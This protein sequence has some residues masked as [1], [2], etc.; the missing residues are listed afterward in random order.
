MIGAIL[1]TF[2]WAMSPLVQGQEPDSINKQ[3]DLTRRFNGR[4]PPENR[5]RPGIIETIWGLLLSPVGCSLAQSL[6]LPEDDAQ[7]DFTAWSPY[8]GLVGVIN[9]ADQIERLASFFHHPGGPRIQGI[10]MGSGKDC[11]AGLLNADR[12]FIQALKSRAPGMEVLFVLDNCIIDVKTDPEARRQYLESV[13][14]TLGPLVDYFQVGNEPD[15]FPEE[16]G[17]TNWISERQYAQAL[18]EVYA[19]AQSQYPGVS[20]KLVPAAFLG[21][22]DGARYLGNLISLAGPLL[23]EMGIIHI[24]FYCGTKQ[25]VYD[26]KFQIERLWPRVRVWVTET[27]TLHRSRHVGYVNARYPIFKRDLHAERIYWW[28]MF[29]VAGGGQFGGFVMAL[30]DRVGGSVIET[31]PLYN[32]LLLP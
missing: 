24:H 28:H 13:F 18:S 10:R 31:S 4:I 8:V 14:R 9:P 21:N 6:T 29:N 27:G 12:K 3:V 16:A 23:T 1:F 7:L 26:Y 20:D 32:A 17:C 19:F 30:Y 25:C 2:L 5:S 22:S 15:C 11:A